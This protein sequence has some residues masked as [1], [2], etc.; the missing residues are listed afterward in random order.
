MFWPKLP[1]RG[2]DYTPPP[3]DALS[4]FH[5]Q[6]PK[7]I[8]NRFTMPP[9]QKLYPR[10]TVKKIVKAHS[11]RNVSKNVDVMVGCRAPTTR[12]EV[13]PNMRSLQVFLDYVLFMQSYG[14]P[15]TNSAWHSDF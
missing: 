15:G 7:P 9:G 8:H 3:R 14:I 11:N 5:S 1:I 10:A 6:R 13:R 12:R 2:P 4:H